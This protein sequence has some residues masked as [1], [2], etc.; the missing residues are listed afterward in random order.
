MLL[1]SASLPRSF[2]V[3]TVPT[4][5]PLSEALSAPALSNSCQIHTRAV[6]LS[7][8]LQMRK[9]MPPPPL[10]RPPLA[11]ALSNSAAAVTVCWSLSIC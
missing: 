4:S 9:P 5:L 7:P 1:R 8:R 2:R 6:S 11:A 10:S 3:A